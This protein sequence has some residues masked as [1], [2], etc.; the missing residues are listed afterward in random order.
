[1]EYYGSSDDVQLLV[2]DAI[3]F[4][5]TTQVTIPVNTVNYDA[6]MVLHA[7][8]GEESTGYTGDCWSAFQTFSRSYPTTN[9]FTE[10]TIAPVRE[11]ECRCTWSNLS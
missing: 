4:A 11:K 1:M 7:G 8:Y 9:G 5:N 10:G 6:V 2:G 3:T